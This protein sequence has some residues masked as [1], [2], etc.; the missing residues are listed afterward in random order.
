MWFLNFRAVKVEESPVRET[1]CDNC[2]AYQRVEEVSGTVSTAEKYIG[3]A[4]PFNKCGSCGVFYYCGKKCQ[5]EA[6][7]HHHKYECPILVNFLATVTLAKHFIER[8]DFRFVLR[9]LCMTRAGRLTK[10]LMRDFY[11]APVGNLRDFVPSMEASYRRL[12]RNMKLLA[13]SPVH[14]D[15]VLQILCFVG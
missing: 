9:F 12:S 4:I 6:W 15:E 13:M 2:F 10:E 14:E 5:K 8:T 3:T 1:T 11:T 7:E